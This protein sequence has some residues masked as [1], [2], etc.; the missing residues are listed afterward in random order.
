MLEFL[1]TLGTSVLGGAS[2]GLVGLYI[3]SL[4]NKYS[5]TRKIIDNTLSEL[6]QLTDRC[7]KVA[8]EVWEKPGEGAD[9][10]N[11]KEVTCLLHEI[12]V[13]A[14]FITDRVKN[15]K[16]RV[17]PAL[18]NFRRATSGDNFDVKGRPADPSRTLAIRS[19]ASELKIAFRTVGYERNS[20]RLW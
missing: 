18:L 1:G 12:N 16:I 6:E 20:F 2:T 19:K 14:S 10:L 7:A 8:S 4:T 15:T 5:D 11:V 3:L 13:F 17:N 9:S